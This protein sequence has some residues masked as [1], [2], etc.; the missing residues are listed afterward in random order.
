MLIKREG[1]EVFRLP[2]DLPDIRASWSPSLQFSTFVGGTL[3]NLHETE[4]FCDLPWELI[5]KK[6]G[7]LAKWLDVSAG[8]P[9]VLTLTARLQPGV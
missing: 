4:R 1:R 8:M 9:R 2:S 5:L 7:E 6:D 3:F